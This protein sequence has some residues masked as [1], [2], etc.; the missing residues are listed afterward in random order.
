MTTVLDEAEKSIRVQNWLTIFEGEEDLF[1]LLMDFEDT[2][3]EIT[4]SKAAMR[5]V[6]RL[7]LVE[8]GE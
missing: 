8:E 1:E 7:D 3:D 6:F 5:V 2:A 4:S